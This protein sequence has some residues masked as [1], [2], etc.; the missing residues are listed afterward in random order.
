MHVESLMQLTHSQFVWKFDT[1]RKPVEMFGVFGGPEM[2]LCKD[3]QRNIQA[4]VTKIWNTG[5]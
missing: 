5:L 1:S 2:A 4:S 3:G